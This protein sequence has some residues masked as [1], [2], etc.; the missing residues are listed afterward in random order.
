MSRGGGLVTPVLQTARLVLRPLTLDDAPAVQRHFGRWNI[1]RHL[2]LAVPW[3]YPPDGA[4]TFIANVA[5]PAMERGDEMLW[6]IT[7]RP[8]PG[9]AIGAIGYRVGGGP[10][11]DRGFWLAE[12]WQG[13]GYMTEAVTAVQDHLFFVLGIPSLRVVNAKGNLASRRVKEKT[14]ARWVGAAHIKHHEGEGEA[15][16]WEVTREAWAAIRRRELG[17]HD[18]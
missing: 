8:A 14:G 4:E 2:S 7:R 16:V 18:V 9:E 1:I 13:R 15:D 5:L 17:P 11:G 10:L 6:A 12:G 3:P